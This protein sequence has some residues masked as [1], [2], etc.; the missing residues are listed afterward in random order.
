LGDQTRF[1]DPIHGFIEVS[2][3]ERGIIDSEIFQR[4]RRIH[5]LGLGFYVYHGATHKRFEHCLGTMNFATR[6]L[7]VLKDKGLLD[8][9]YSDEDFKKLRQQVRLAALLHDIGHP[10]F[11]HAGDEKTLFPNGLSHE[12]YSVSIIMNYLADYIEEN[13]PEI[14]VQEI[15]SLIKGERTEGIAQ[16]LFL[17]DLINGELDTDKMDYLLRDSYY[18]GVEYGNYDHQRLLETLTICKHEDGVWQ[19]GVESDGIHAVETFKFAGYWMFLQVYFHKTRRVFD[20][21]LTNLLRD[22]LADAHGSK[23][24][25]RDNIEEYVKY[26]DIMIQHLLSEWKGDNYWAKMIYERT[27]FSEVYLLRHLAEPEVGLFLHLEEGLG[28][29]YGP[30]EVFFDQADKVPYQQVLPLGV[31]EEQEPARGTPFFPIPVKDIHDKQIRN[32]IEYSIPLARMQ[33]INVLRIYSLKSKKDE[34]A[35]FCQE[36]SQ[37]YRKKYKVRREGR[38]DRP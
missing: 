17:L 8:G 31:I 20:Y 24:P 22:V 13:F 21:Y 10:P 6:A 34:V 28:E 2:P 15:V 9:A 23:F 25:S 33:K 36:A 5:Q 19:L 12:D 18:C 1:R 32:I 38:Y 37:E 26:D 14:K 29:K 27:P 7:Q 3:Q 30:K 11:S 35:Q 16:Q 4:L